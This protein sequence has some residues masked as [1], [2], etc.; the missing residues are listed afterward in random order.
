MKKK[1]IKIKKTKIWYLFLYFIFIPI[2]N[3][4]WT[5]II[6]FKGRIVFFRYK[7]KGITKI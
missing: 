1:F 6:N 7:K 4:L 2:F 3:F 5:N